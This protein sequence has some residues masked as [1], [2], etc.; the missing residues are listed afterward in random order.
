[1]TFKWSRRHVLDTDDWSR[2]EIEAVL[3]TTAAMVEVLSRPIRRAPPLRGRTVV[4]FFAEASTRTR[5][6]F[7]LAAR[8]LSADVVNITSSGSSV[9]KGESLYDTVR[10]LQA[11]GGDIVVMRHSSSGAPYFV[12]ERTDAAVINAG[13]GWHAHPTQGLLDAYTLRGA[14]GD[15]AGKR[16]VIVGDVV[17]SRVARSDINTLVPLGATV[18]LSGP[19]TLMPA[20]WRCGQPPP[21]VT[22]E[23]DLDRALDGADAVIALR[24]QKERQ[25]GGLL[26]SLREYTRVW[27]VTEARVARMRPGAPVMHPGPMNEGVEI[28]AAVAHGVRSLVERQVTNG[29]AVRMALLYLLVGTP[30]LEAA[31]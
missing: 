21:G 16:V 31:P 24:L 22:Y 3:G 29:V 17:H 11:L 30:S 6:S 25:E 10:T 7:E 18:T 20:A 12:S 23:A 1:M 14:L 27:G 5:V 9:E 15:L 26:P 13:D 4:L 19:P 28:D 8:T 2:E